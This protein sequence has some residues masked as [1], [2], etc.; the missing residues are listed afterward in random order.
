[1]QAGVRLVGLVHRPP[2]EVKSA[3]AQCCLLHAVCTEPT[4]AY[5]HTLYFPSL[6]YIS[7][8]CLNRDMLG[9]VTLNYL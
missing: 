1:M 7:L 9:V 4:H 8:Q 3:D 2:P 6:I 5:T